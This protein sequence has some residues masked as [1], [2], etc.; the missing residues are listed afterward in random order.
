MISQPNPQHLINSSR[1]SD[2]KV[3]LDW[4]TDDAQQRIAH[5]ARVSNPKNQHNRDTA[6]KLLK[7]LIKNK[8]YSPFEMC[9]MCVVVDT[10][11]QISQQILRHRS[12]HFQEFSQRYAD[13]G[14]LGNTVIPLLRRQDL[15]NRQNSINDFKYEEVSHFYRRMSELFEESEHL[16]QEMV[17][18]GVA[19]ECARG[20]LPVNTRTRLS[21]NA[22]I[23]DWMFYC[24]VRSDKSTQ[25]EHRIIAELVMEIF[26][27]EM[28]D[29]YEA[30]F[31]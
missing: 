9:N 17:S 19:K 7:Y 25:Y 27:K 13:T 21:I 11:R 12:M 15:K 31:T 6:V 3:T 2:Y 29:I 8:H 20:I 1:C 14:M 18:A 16:Y 23:R 4:I 5:H 22:T 26:E 10:T 28:P 30:F 24:D